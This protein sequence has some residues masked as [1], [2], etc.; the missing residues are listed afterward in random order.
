MARSY[1]EQEKRSVLR[2]LRCWKDCFRAAFAA[3]VGAIRAPDYD[4]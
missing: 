1:P 3:G 2:T 4:L